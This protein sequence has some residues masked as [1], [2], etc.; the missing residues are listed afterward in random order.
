MFVP[1]SS[2]RRCF[3]DVNFQFQILSSNSSMVPLF[4]PTASVWPFGLNATL[5]TGL[6]S[7]KVAIRCLLPVS[8]SPTSPPSSPTASVWPFGLKATLLTGLPW[9][10]W[11]SASRWPCST[12]RRHHPAPRRRGSGRSG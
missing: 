5:L 6:P 1:T 8:H 11:R 3:S 9:T 12:G 4:S 7:D 2:Q 10:R